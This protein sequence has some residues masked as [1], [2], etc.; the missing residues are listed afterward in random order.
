MNEYLLEGIRK[1]VEVIIIDEHDDI[2]KFLPEKK[3]EYVRQ[4]LAK[5]AELHQN[6]ANL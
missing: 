5:A 2:T 3:A 4:M 6:N 1:V